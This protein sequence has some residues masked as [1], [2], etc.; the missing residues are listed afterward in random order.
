MN[1]LFLILHPPEPEI[2]DTNSPSDLASYHVSG[3]IELLTMDASGGNPVSKV[4]KT[5][6]DSFVGSA[7]TIR[8][9]QMRITIVH[10][11]PFLDSTT[12]GSRHWLH[13]VQVDV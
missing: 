11:E 2:G 3:A 6:S 7:A 10:V 13:G 8:W 9:Y 4:A 1:R 12:A 5:L